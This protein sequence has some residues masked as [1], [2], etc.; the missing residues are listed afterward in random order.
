MVRRGLGG[1]PLLLAVALT[2]V[3]GVVIAAGVFYTGWWNLV[4]GTA[5]P[6]V[7]DTLD[8]AK[9]S[10]AV[11]GG[12]GGVVALVVAF[13][14]QRLQEIEHEFTAAADRR[15]DVRLFNERFT[16][17]VQLLGDAS[18]PAV[19]LSGVYA[20]A[21]LADDWPEGRQTCVDVLCGYMRLPYGPASAPA[22]E[23]Q[24]RRA[25]LAVIRD[26]LCDNAAVSWSSCDFDLH[27]AVFDGG[28]LDG[29]RLMG[30]IR[31]AGAKFI[32][33]GLSWRSGTFDRCRLDCAGMDLSSGDL[34]FD[35]STFDHARCDLSEMTIDSG[36]LSLRDAVIVE[37]QLD[38]HGL[39]MTGGAVHF[40]NAQ[41]ITSQPLRLAT[42]L[43]HLAHSTLTAGTVSFGRATFD[44]NHP[45]PFITAEGRTVDEQRPP[46]PQDARLWPW[47][48]TFYNATFGG[49][50][51]SFAHAEINYGE[52]SFR[53][54]TIKDGQLDFSYAH[55]RLTRIMFMG[56][57]MQGG[58]V[59]F[60]QAHLWQQ[61]RITDRDVP[62]YLDELARTDPSERVDYTYA[63]LCRDHPGLPD[64]AIEFTDA[65]LAGGEI[66]FRG[67]DAGGGV[68][69][70]KGA[71]L[72]DTVIR[73]VG[74]GLRHLLVVLWRMQFPAGDGYIEF[75]YASH[76]MLLLSIGMTDAEQAR[77]VIEGC[78]GIRRYEINTID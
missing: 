11:T 8:L 78:P 64:S 40:D 3:L 25:L 59:V 51:V 67:F 6:P 2:V 23:G 26:H 71:Q 69:D 53:D 65:R 60:D 22:G 54:A 28:N 29:A 37:G 46:P 41:I 35:G 12:V 74:C 15:D 18:S 76:P 24:V 9:V 17:A 43:I 13:R 49:T 42:G 31:F 32:G 77:L 5:R 61:A 19:R 1:A 30:M 20:V 50:T 72:S 21:S 34:T 44:R 7:S 56:A 48:V 68:V 73:F 47:A 14:R 45:T 57:K 36:T 75:T 62:D 58:T 52:I 27:D 4:R 63:H 38:M 39:K 16:S 33:N 10:L 55:L 70:F 66:S